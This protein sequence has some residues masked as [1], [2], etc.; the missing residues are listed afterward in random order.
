MQHVATPPDRP[1]ISGIRPPVT[2]GDWLERVE[3]I[4]TGRFMSG[5]SR[6]ATAAAE[7][8]LALAPSAYWYLCRSDLRFGFVVFLW[9]VQRANPLLADDGAVAPFD[10]GGLWHGHIQTALILSESERQQFVSRHSRPVYRWLPELTSWLDRNYASPGDYVIGVPPRAGLAGIV[11]DGRN[12]APAWTWEARLHKD[13]FRGQI[14]IE[15]IFWTAADRSA[16]ED[17]LETREI[18]DREA[19][20]LLE[21]IAAVTIE[22]PATERASEE[23]VRYLLEIV[24]N[25]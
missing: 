12:E 2:S 25:E 4:L 21:L 20:D 7:E 13:S 5:P 11:Y 24:N 23:V 14:A 17:W 18:D 10:T 9:R 15:R 3:D 6:G 16:F 1:W 8:G 19:V 22:T